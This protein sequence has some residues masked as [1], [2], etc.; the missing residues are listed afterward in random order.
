MLY[1]YN[2]HIDYN[3]YLSILNELISNALEQLPVSEKLKN[4]KL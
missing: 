1:N 3:I 2:N 4:L